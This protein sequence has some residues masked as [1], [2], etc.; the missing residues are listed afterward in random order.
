MTTGARQCLGIFLAPLVQAT[1][2]GIADVSFAL[3][4]GQLCWGLSQPLWGMAADRFGF[5]A[6]IGAGAV[7][8]ALGLG[9]SP[10]MHDTAGLVWTLGVLSALGGGAGSFAL[11]M[12]ATARLLRPEQRSMAAGILNAGSSFGQFLFAPLSQLLIGLVGWASALVSLG[13]LMLGTI[14]LALLLRTGKGSAAAPAA[15]SGPGLRQQLVEARGDASYWCLHV[16]FL[17][18]GF[19][20]AFLV[21]HLPTE[22]ALCGLGS[23]VGATAI[24]IIGLTNIVGSLAAGYLGRRVRLKWLLFGMYLIRA[25][26]V[27]AYLAAPRSETNFYLFAVVL[28]LTWLATVPPTVGLVGK[29]FGV[30]HLA[31]LFGLTLVSHQIGGFL[32]AWLGGLAMSYFGNYSWMWY[33][34]I[35]LALGAAL[36]NLPIREAP[37]EP[38][39]AGNPGPGPASAAGSDPVR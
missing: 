25:L 14:P 19:H 20:V 30:R 22:V 26:A 32:G 6:V 33:A 1:G 34:D 31:T 21:T 38:A 5:F 9:A 12:G 37:L 35:V 11:L 29:L 27:A 10:A 16:G 7:M 13:V 28:G 23:S 39:D 4:V 15:A 18:C 8:L 24:G 2:L 17:T 36:V 3:A